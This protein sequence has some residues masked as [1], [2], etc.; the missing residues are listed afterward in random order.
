MDYESAWKDLK[1]KIESNYEFYKAGAMCTLAESA[2]GEAM[3]KDVLNDMKKLEYK[4]NTMPVAKTKN[5]YMACSCSKDD[6]ELFMSVAKAL[7]EEGYTVFVPFELKIDEKDENGNWK[8]S[9]EDWGTLVADKDLAMI[10][11][12]DT[13]L[14]LSDGRISSA[15]KNFEHGFAYAKG[16]RVIVL[17]YTDNDTSLMT[18][19]GSNTFKN[20]PR[21]CLVSA[22]I[23]AVK[24]VDEKGKCE[25]LIT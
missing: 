16:K 10:K 24:G 5:I 20:V 3:M 7:R 14:L 18:Y 21:A 12:Y 13:F 22:A 15:G 2:C 9:Q 4:Y 1:E 17:Q 6:R 8:Y 25:T 19:R 11:L 23:A